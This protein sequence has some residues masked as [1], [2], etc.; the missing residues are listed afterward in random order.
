[1]IDGVGC[2]RRSMLTAYMHACMYEYMHVC[3]MYAVCMHIYM[4]VC[5]PKLYYAQ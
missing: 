1:M 3:S 4:G 2:F 5:L